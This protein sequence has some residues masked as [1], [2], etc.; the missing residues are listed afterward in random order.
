[1]PFLDPLGIHA[2]GL[3]EFYQCITD[4]FWFVEITF[5]VQVGLEEE[6]HLL[7][8][9]YHDFYWLHYINGIV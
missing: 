2:P 8:S 3:G 6:L 1:M 4:E 9:Y 5:F 7:N